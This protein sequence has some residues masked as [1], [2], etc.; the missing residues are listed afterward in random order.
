M[1]ILAHDFWVAYHPWNK[2]HTSVNSL[3]LLLVV[4]S[5]DQV[6]GALVS[7]VWSSVRLQYIENLTSWL[8]KS[9]T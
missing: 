6:S 1:W 5:L 3:S 8:Q 9:W 7:H 2:S 4:S